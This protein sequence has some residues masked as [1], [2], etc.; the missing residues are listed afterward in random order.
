MR[1]CAFFC[2][3][4]EVF[5]WLSSCVWIAKPEMLS[6]LILSALLGAA[7]SQTLQL[8][9]MS[10]IPNQWDDIPLT[11]TS[12]DD[13]LGENFF[14]LLFN[15]SRRNHMF[16]FFFQAT[17]NVNFYRCSGTPSANCGGCSFYN[18]V[19]L[20]DKKTTLITTSNYPWTAYQGPLTICMAS[21]MLTLYQYS[22]A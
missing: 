14:R 15:V 5:G 3:C 7:T 4:G 18:T 9:D 10:S 11:W 1:H 2:R 12:S 21:S 16:L 22:H 19:T 6:N 20:N 8:N 13:L 17:A